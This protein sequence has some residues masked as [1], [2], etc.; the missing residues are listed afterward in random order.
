MIRIPKKRKVLPKHHAPRKGGKTSRFRLSA[1][2]YGPEMRRGSRIK[3]IGVETLGVRR[4]GGVSEWELQLD[5]ARK[6]TSNSLNTGEVGGIS[7]EREG[8]INSVFMKSFFNYLFDPELSELPMPVPPRPH[9]KVVHTDDYYDYLK[10]FGRKTLNVVRNYS[11]KTIFGIPLGKLKPEKFSVKMYSIKKDTLSRLGPLLDHLGIGEV[12]RENAKVLGNYFSSYSHLINLKSPKMLSYVNISLNDKPYYAVFRV[13]GIDVGKSQMIYSMLSFQEGNFNEDAEREVD[14]LSMRKLF[15]PLVTPRENLDER[16]LKLFDAPKKGKTRLRH[17]QKVLP[18]QAAQVSSVAVVTRRRYEPEVKFEQSAFAGTLLKDLEH[19]LTE[20]EAE[21]PSDLV[22]KIVNYAQEKKD[23]VWFGQLNPTGLHLHIEGVYKNSIV[24]VRRMFEDFGIAN[25]NSSTMKTLEEKLFSGPQSIAYNPSYISAVVNTEI[26]GSPY[27]AL[28][29]VR[30]VYPEDR[31]IGYNLIKLNEGHRNLGSVTELKPETV[32]KLHK[33]FPHVAHEGR[34]LDL[35]RERSYCIGCFE[36][37]GVHKEWCNYRR[38]GASEISIRKSEV[39]ARQPEL[40]EAKAPRVEPIVRA[41]ESSQQDFSLGKEL[42]E[43][44]KLESYEKGFPEI[45]EGKMK[46]PEG[47]MKPVIKSSET[48]DYQRRQ[49][50]QDALVVMENLE[51]LGVYED[52]DGKPVIDVVTQILPYL[53]NFGIANGAVR[54]SDI[55]LEGAEGFEGCLCREVTFPDGLNYVFVE[56][57]GKIPEAE[58]YTDEQISGLVISTKSPA[59]E[60]HKSLTRIKDIG[61]NMSKD[62]DD[63]RDY[64]SETLKSL[65][66]SVPRYKTLEAQK[67]SNRALEEAKNRIDAT[68]KEAEKSM[69]DKIYAGVKIEAGKVWG[70]M[71][72]IK[73]Y[74]DYFEGQSPK[75]E[76]PFTTEKSAAGKKGK[77]LP[78]DYVKERLSQPGMERLVVGDLAKE[79]IEATGR[80]ADSVNPRIYET[81]K[82]FGYRRVGEGIYELRKPNAK[83]TYGGKTH[84]IEKVKVYI[85]EHPKSSPEDVLGGTG[86]PVA[87]VYPALTKLFKNGKLSREKKDGAFVYSPK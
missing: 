16:Y 51:K 38:I 29:E 82:A 54:V 83:R 87:T 10:G 43:V 70:L 32:F 71:N 60:R 77:V 4:K 58:G 27:T 1:V 28:L 37:P 49:E 76:K 12:S 26:N 13:D 19:Y 44:P 36:R 84:V 65:T 68:I 50:I 59:R 2:A 78:T 5:G 55:S 41:A 79:T 14:V 62:L 81:L 64:V 40:S 67:M 45:K 47:P 74:D 30:S 85:E 34:W 57:E 72:N 22:D 42:E 8:Y 25:I 33:S 23:R 53:R 46:I 7:N 15:G 18:L 35:S 3:G 48:A 80:S 86:I 21:I 66:K 9:H 31:Y 39:P 52:V 56:G 11:R 73:E 20:P 24:R 61:L 6:E 75:A 69:I 63:A 17:V